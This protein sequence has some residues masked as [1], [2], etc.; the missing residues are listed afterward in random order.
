MKKLVLIALGALS[1]TS[2][3]N[4]GHGMTANEVLMELKAGNARYMNKQGSSYDYRAD[5][6]LAAEK[7]Q[8]PIAYILSCMDS[9][10]IPEKAFDQTAGKLYVSRVAGNVISKNMLASMEYA[11]LTGAKALVIMGHTHCGA[12]ISTCKGS[13]FG[14]IDHLLDVIRP[15]VTAQG[16][17][18]NCE[19]HDVVDKIAIQNVKNMI[20]K[21]LKKSSYVADKVKSQEIILIGAMHDIDTGKITF[22]N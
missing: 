1:V 5:A 2:F 4:G 15:A 21:T 6:K 16:S 12:V 22:L 11:V 18:P 19:S 17:A 14:N 13:A 3:A 9:R 7:G 20:A 8:Q 10:A